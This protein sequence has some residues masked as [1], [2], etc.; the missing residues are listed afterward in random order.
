MWLLLVVAGN[1][2]ASE[3]RLLTFTNFSTFHREASGD[4][5][6]L[7]SPPV[8]AGIRWKQLVVSWNVT[9]NIAL[10][11]AARPM[12]PG[13]ARFLSLGRWALAA[14][15]KT[16]RESVNGQEA[17][18]GEVQTDVLVLR[19][20]A[21][22]AEVRLE[23]LGP[24]AGLR[25]LALA[26][27]GDGGMEESAKAASAVWGRDLP[28][29]VRSQADFPEGVSRWCSPTSTTM[30]MAYWGERQTRPD[31]IPTV[32]ETARGVFDPG[33]DGT[34]NWPF[35]MAFAGS[36]PGLNAVV[37]RWESLADLER[38][39]ES[40]APAAASVSYAMLKGRP[41]AEPGDGHLVVVRGFTAAGDV[42][43]NDPGVRRERVDR[44]FPRGDFDRAW[45]HS[46]RTVYLV[47][48]DGHPLPQGPR[49]PN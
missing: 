29:P 23:V 25:R 14:S 5:T 19:E 12:L 41:V 9:T 33:W 34:G 7:S 42:R 47:W 18:W 48:P 20:A 16:P 39:V 15:P 10:S 43:V 35:N 36:P 17:S 3:A 32:P 24:E 38:W 11:V 37:A 49:Y 44:V 8:E 30:L 45:T 31:W 22:S 4:L 26:F 27:S 46:R 21:T 2:V 1:I 28:V 40:G 6:V 13:G